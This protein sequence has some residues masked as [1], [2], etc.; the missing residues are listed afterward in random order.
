VVPYTWCFSNLCVAA[1]AAS[2]AMIRTLE[3]GRTLSVE[4]ADTNL[5]SLTATIPV[6]QFGAAY[7]GTPAQTIEQVIDE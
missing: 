2:S 1:A 4:V 6:G 7:S 3:K 5:V